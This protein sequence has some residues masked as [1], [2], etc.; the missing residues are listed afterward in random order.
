MQEH[1]VRIMG[2]D[3]RKLSLRGGAAEFSFYD[4][5]IFNS[6]KN[7]TQNVRTVRVKLRFCTPIAVLYTNCG[8]V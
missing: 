1:K 6:L 2:E 7:F 3:W 5:F 4:N 8:S